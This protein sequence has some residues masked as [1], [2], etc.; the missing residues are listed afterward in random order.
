MKKQLQIALLMMI[1]AG[2]IIAQIEV[3]STYTHISAEPG[4]TESE[5][6]NSY[7]LVTNTSDAPIELKCKREIVT[8]IASSQNRFCWGGTCYGVNDAVSLNTHTLNPD[9][10][11]TFN[12]VDGFAGYYIPN[13]NTGMTQ[14]RY[15]FYEASNFTNETSIIIN[16]CMN[17][18]GTCE[19]VLGI[20]EA[21]KAVATSASP[22]PATNQI[23]ISYASNYSGANTL[24]I[25]NAIGNEVKNVNLMATEGTVSLDVSEYSEGLYFYTFMRDGALL[26]SKR[27]IVAR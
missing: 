5:E 26:T 17:D 15:V 9:E 14:I 18:V 11:I 7:I 20:E 3:S 12:G 19:A 6:M 2:N 16:Y 22:N 4:T 10:S 21:D 1:S 23:T 24:K 8:E 13:G 27:F 25:Y